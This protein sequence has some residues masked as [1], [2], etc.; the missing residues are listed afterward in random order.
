MNRKLTTRVKEFDL[1]RKVL[2]MGIINVTPDSFYEGSRCAS[3]SVLDRAEQF[4]EAGADLLDVGG[5]STRPGA[6][7][8]LL[9]D[10]I[11]RVIPAVERIVRRFPTVPVSVDTT[12]ADVARRSVEAGASL[13]NDVSAL[14]GDPSMASVVAEAKVP[15][16]LMHMQ[17]TP[18]TMQVAPRYKDVVGE[19]KAFFVERIRFA[20]EQG[21]PS[22]RI[23]LDPGIGFGKTYDH[24]LHILNAL[25][26]FSEMGYPLMVGTSRKAFI[27]RA[28]GSEHRHLPAEQRYEGTLSSCL[29][30]ATHGADVLRVHDVKGVRQVLDLWRTIETV[31]VKE[32]MAC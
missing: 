6:Q 12:K 26:E 2:L 14:R 25:R 11:S 27:G 23:L 13:I 3:G 28:L 19:I 30:A 1:S 31:T 4:V 8:G 21:I 29:W 7:P 5:E 16:V 9:D 32:A 15:V 18:R 17:G 22:D 10:E 20:E 24:N